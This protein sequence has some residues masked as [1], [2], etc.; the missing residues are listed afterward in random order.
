[1][2]PITAI[3]LVAGLVML[4][5][6]FVAPSLVAGFLGVAALITAGLR[7]IGIVDS[8]PVS[9]LI[10]VITS[11]ALVIPF[12]PMMKRIAG[13]AEVNKDRTDVDEDRDS[14][15]EIVTVV[16]DVSEEHDQGRIR[17]QGT[18]W[19]ARCT[20][21]TI[22]KGDK[23]HLVYR[24]GSLWVVEPVPQGTD[25]AAR[26]LFVDEASQS[27]VVEVAPHERKA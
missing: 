24:E 3:F 20:T 15:G 23:A 25:G 9:L 1:M 11:M 22:K 16:E 4:A 12:R 13:R 14:M 27:Q 10:W 6:E 26:E 17:F 18:T 5:S 21:G 8:I 19:Q 2:E 7:G